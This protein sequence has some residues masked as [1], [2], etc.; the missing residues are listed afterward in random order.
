MRG[1]PAPVERALNAAL[2]RGPGYEPTPIGPEFDDRS[3][4]GYYI[5]FRAK[6]TAPTAA[7]PSALPAI[8]LIQL[9]LGWWERDVAGDQGARERFLALCQAIEQRGEPSAD[10]LRWPM[11]VEVP[12]YGLAPGWSSALAQGQ[13]ASVFVRA[14]LAT[15][16]DR[17]AAL[18]R[19][20]VGPFL[21]G[22]E[23]DLVAHTAAGP[24]LEEAPSRPPSHVLNGWMSALWGLWDVQLGLEDERAR[25]A[26]VTGVD[27]LREMLPAYDTGW[28]TLYGLYPHALADL[29]K[30]IYHRFH[31][32]QLE[33]YYRLTGEPGFKETA[34]RWAA[35]DRLPNRL[36]ALGQKGAFSLLDGRRRRRWRVRNA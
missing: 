1:V 30:P 29:A 8:Q 9:A 35:Y 15:G 36:L 17:Y 33:V 5:D 32:T 23:A 19:R 16:E 26:F 12:K 20:A 11:R 3:V 2:S 31:V 13:A 27:C 10:G 6:T 24:I 14:H 25:A 22:E 7:D 28:W 4:R 18:A 21:A 34:A